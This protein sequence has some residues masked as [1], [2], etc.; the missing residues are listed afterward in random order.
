ME[1]VEGDDLS[2]R[3]A[4]GAI[5]V[6]EALPIAQAD[7]GGARGGARAGDHSPRSEARE[8]QGARR[9]HREGARLRPRESDGAVARARRAGH[10]SMSPT[11]TTPAMTQAGMILGTAA[12]MSPGAGEG[13]RGRQAQRRV[14]VRVRALRDGNRPA[15]VPGDDVADTLASVLKAEPDW[16]TIP[17]DVP[18]AV[19]ELIQGCLRKNPKERIS[20]LSTA[21]F[22]L[23]RPH[24]VAGA[25]SVRSVVS[26][27]TRGDRDGFCADLGNACRHLGLAAQTGA[28]RLGDSP[29][30]HTVRWT[31][32]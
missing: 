25:I 3:I 16:N 14:G 32:S 4:R 24:V 21:L 20:S 22:V 6:D 2:Q 9:R 31:S 15:G 26:L 13:T 1:L 18:R 19:C 7:R 23:S 10:A 12:Y 27:A 8:Y 29:R 5:P 28:S 11:I 17:S 30:V